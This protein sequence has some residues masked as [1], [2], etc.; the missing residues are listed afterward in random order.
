M[1][2]LPI[3]RAVKAA[4]KYRKLSQ[5]QLAERMGVQRPTISKIESCVD[6]SPN[7][8]TL[9]LVASGLNVDL[10]Q[11]VSWAERKMKRQLAKGIPQ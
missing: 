6:Y 8:R 10:S 11:L 3:G 9:T 5:A 4:R 1:N 7:L 2:A